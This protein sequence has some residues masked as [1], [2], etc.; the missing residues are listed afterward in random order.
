MYNF[1]EWIWCIPKVS[2]IQQTH[3]IPYSNTRFCAIRFSWFHVI[4][5]SLLMSVRIYCI[6]KGDSKA[7]ESYPS[8]LVDCY[9][10][11]EM[12]QKCSSQKKRTKAQLYFRVCNVFSCSFIACVMN[13]PLYKDIQSIQQQQQQQWWEQ[14]ALV[15]VNKFNT[16]IYKHTHTFM[17]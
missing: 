3:G 14:F 4:S 13:L 16:Y 1:R 15:I 12:L 11:K 10:A 9:S 5:K 17:Y 7:Q 8:L 2:Q 6:F